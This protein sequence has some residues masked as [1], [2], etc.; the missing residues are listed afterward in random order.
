VLAAGT[1]IFDL[2]MTA[3]VDATRAGNMAH[4]INH[5]CGPCAHSRTITVRE[6]DTGEP[7]DHVIIIASRDLPPGGAAVGLPTQPHID[8]LLF[9]VLTVSTTTTSVAS[10]HALA[11]NKHIAGSLLS[12]WQW[13]NVIAPEAAGT[14]FLSLKT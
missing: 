12:S 10:T 2:N 14:A 9:A 5:S 7:V 13:L 6:L 1:Y 11:L 4:L 8:L 3:S